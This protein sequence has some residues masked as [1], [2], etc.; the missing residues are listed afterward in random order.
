MGWSYM[1]TVLWHH[2]DQSVTRGSVAN[3]ATVLCLIFCEFLDSSSNYF[4]RKW[5]TNLVTFYDATGDFWR[6]WHEAHSCITARF[7]EQRSCCW[8]RALRVCSQPAHRSSVHP[9]PAPSEQILTLLSLQ[10]WL[11]AQA[12]SVCWLI[13]PVLRCKPK[14]ISV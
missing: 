5:L 13:T 1:T 9:S 10:R 4:S 6:L 11:I 3:V 12:K 14:H 2:L 7:T 8:Y